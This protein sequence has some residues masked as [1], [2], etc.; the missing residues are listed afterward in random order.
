MIE[1]LHALG[2]ELAA[3]PWV[4]SYAA[5]VL[6]GIAFQRRITRWCLGGKP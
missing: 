4:M 5:G 2:A 1:Q 6:S 3:N